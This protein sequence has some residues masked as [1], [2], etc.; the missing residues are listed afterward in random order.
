L[1]VQGK[2]ALAKKRIKSLLKYNGRRAA[3]IL[4]E[5]GEM[6][7]TGLERRKKKHISSLS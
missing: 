2:G 4:T 6:G 3:L 1:T 5:K 7:G